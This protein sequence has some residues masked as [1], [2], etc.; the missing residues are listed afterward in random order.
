V[1]QLRQDHGKYIHV[2]PLVAFLND[3][4]VSIA[5]V[6]AIVQITVVI[7]F[8]CM[9]LCVW[10]HDNAHVLEIGFYVHLNVPFKGGQD[11][12]LFLLQILHQD[13]DTEPFV[14]TLSEGQ[15]DISQGNTGHA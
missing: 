1:L 11:N 13:S 14:M 10:A 7:L 4:N 8:Q 2:V 6:D 3:H 9:A 5:L 12:L 15:T